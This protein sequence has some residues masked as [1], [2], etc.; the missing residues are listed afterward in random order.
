L[1]LAARVRRAIEQYRLLMPGETVTVGVSGGPDSLCLL[2][3]LRQLAP[4]LSLKL[5]VAHLNHQMRGEEA[6]ADADF[7]GELAAAWGLPATIASVDVPE[8]ARLHKLAPEE[9]ARRARYAFLTRAANQIGAR[10]IAV[11][12]NADDQTETV[13]MHWLRGAGLAGLRVGPGQ[14]F[15]L[16]NIDAASQIAFRDAHAI[17]LIG[18]LVTQGAVLLLEQRLELTQQCG[19]LADELF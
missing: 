12:H 1:A 8:L 19:L 9:A 16:E 5:H 7:V 4:D 11:A 2:H 13:L 3:V 6:D 17:E 18:V 14:A 10:T 15:V